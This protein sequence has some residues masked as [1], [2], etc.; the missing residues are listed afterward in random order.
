MQINLHFFFIL[1]LKD[2][3]RELAYIATQGIFVF[4]IKENGKLCA[5]AL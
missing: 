4:L 2:S 1:K 3:E 5:I